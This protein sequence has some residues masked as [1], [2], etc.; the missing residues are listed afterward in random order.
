MNHTYIN[1]LFVGGHVLCLDVMHKRVYMYIKLYV[2]MG[3]TYVLEIDK[4]AFV[5]SE[6]I[7]VELEVFLHLFF[8]LRLN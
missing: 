7:Y 5:F 4:S 6:T 8:S 2:T 3:I 1:P